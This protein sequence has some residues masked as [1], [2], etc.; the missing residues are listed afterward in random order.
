MVSLYYIKE[1]E[2]DDEQREYSWG[3]RG[4]FPDYVRSIQLWYQKLASGYIWITCIQI[5][6][7]TDVVMKCM[8]LHN[9]VQQVSR[10]HGWQ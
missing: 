3:V 4:L 6:F 2:D 9:H 5:L 7:S 10:V 8:H 1:E